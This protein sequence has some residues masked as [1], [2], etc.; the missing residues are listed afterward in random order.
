MYKEQSAAIK[1]NYPVIFRVSGLVGLMLT[2]LSFLT[3]PRFTNK[4]VLDEEVQIVIEQIDI[5][6]DV[7]L[8]NNNL[9][10]FVKDHFISESW[11]R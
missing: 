9:N 3:F 5:P 10:L 1:V 11:K 2:I 8:F 7:Y 4:M 6:R